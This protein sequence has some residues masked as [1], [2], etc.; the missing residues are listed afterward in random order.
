MTLTDRNKLNDTVLIILITIGLLLG[1]NIIY[2]K[3]SVWRQGKKEL[4]ICLKNFI[5]E[6][7]K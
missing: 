5:K 3:Y 2:T 4:A 1:G 7:K 6:N